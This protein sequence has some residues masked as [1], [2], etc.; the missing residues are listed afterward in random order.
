MNEKAYLVR[1]KHSD[2]RFIILAGKKSIARKAMKDYLEEG[3]DTG[4]I[5]DIKRIRLESEV[6]VYP[7]TPLPKE[8][9]GTANIPNISVEEL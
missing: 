7:L 2:A 8:S 1:M 5:K 6:K 4:K 3:D 9:N